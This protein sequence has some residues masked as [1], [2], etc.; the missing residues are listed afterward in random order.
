MDVGHMPARRAVTFFARLLLN[1]DKPELAL[2]VLGVVQNQNYTT[3]RNLKVKCLFKPLHL[4]IAFQADLY[5]FRYS[6]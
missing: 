4:C 5:A 2:E 1:N 6:Y 3:I